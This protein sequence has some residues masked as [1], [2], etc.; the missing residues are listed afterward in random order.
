MNVHRLACKCAVLLEPNIIP[1]GDRGQRCGRQIEH[2]PA[3]LPRHFH[4]QLQE[5]H[6]RGLLRKA[7]EVRQQKK[8]R[9]LG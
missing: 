8:A 2:D 9:F 3:L 6:R 1:G 5:D 4:Q 7:T